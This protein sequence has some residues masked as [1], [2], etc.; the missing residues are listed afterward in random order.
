[1]NYSLEELE[2]L[3]VTLEGLGYRL[4]HNDFTSKREDRAV[5]TCL[6]IVT[7]MIDERRAEPGATTEGFYIC[8][9]C[10]HEWPSNK[11]KD[12]CHRCGTQVEE[13]R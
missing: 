5:E 10:G 11:Q 1:M 2:R 12:V 8:P 9:D 3:H 13:D 6:K 7:E 4:N